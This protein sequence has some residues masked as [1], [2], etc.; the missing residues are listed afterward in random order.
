[1]AKPNPQTPVQ[2]LSSHVCMLYR[3]TAPTR[4]PIRQYGHVVP[5]QSCVQQ[6]LYPAQLHYI[7][8]AGVLRQARVEA[9]LALHAG[10][11]RAWDHH[12]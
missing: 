6:L 8:L 5:R 11:P 2:V 10:T 12:L 4:L 9:E 3:M 7:R 1:M